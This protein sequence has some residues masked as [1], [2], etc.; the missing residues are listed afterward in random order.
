MSTPKKEDLHP[1]TLED[2]QRGTDLWTYNSN[3]K[4]PMVIQVT[5]WYPDGYVNV[6]GNNYRLAYLNE[7]SGFRGYVLDV[8]KTY[9]VMTTI[10]IV[11]LDDDDSDCI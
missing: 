10:K 1:A 5:H 3:A 11:D 9:R 6:Q 7:S 8:N 2:L 4:D